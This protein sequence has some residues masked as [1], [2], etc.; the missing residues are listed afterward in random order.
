[1][2]REC[3]FIGVLD[4]A[5]GLCEGLGGMTIDEET[6]LSYLYLYN[7]YNVALE[8]FTYIY[9]CILF[10]FIITIIIITMFIDFCF[11]FVQKYHFSMCHSISNFN[12]II[13]IYIYN[14]GRNL[15][16]NFLT[17][18]ICIFV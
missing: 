7:V 1:M 12:G 13:I 9:N 18:I 10:E 15:G 6:Y 4:V 8:R 5:S 14:L 2:Y 17:I 11:R 16:L 3:G